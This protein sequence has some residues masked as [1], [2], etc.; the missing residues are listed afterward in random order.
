MVLYVSCD[1]K[2]MQKSKHKST[3]RIIQ[4][5]VVTF[6]ISL[7]STVFAETPPNTGVILKVNM[8]GLNAQSL[9]PSY[10]EPIGNG[11]FVIDNKFQALN[12]KNPC[13]EYISQIKSGLFDCEPNFILNTS[14]TPNDTNYNTLWGMAKI[15][16]AQAWDLSTGSQEVIVAIVDTGIDYTHPDISANMWQ[17]PNEIAGNG[18]D[19]DGNGIIDD[20]Y[21]YNAI[22]N[23]GNPMDDNGH[24]THCAGTIGGVGNNSR[25]VAGVNWNIKMIGAKF[26]SGS[27]SGSLSDAIKALD[28][29]TNLKNSGVN[30]IASNNSWGGGGFSSSLK[31][32]IT[33]AKNAG[34]IFVAAAGNSANNNDSSPSYP[35]SYDVENVISVAATDSNDNLA[36]FSNYGATSVDIAA[37]GVQINSTIP[38]NRYSYFSGTSMA[39]PHVTGAIALLKSY[40]NLSMTQLI[41]RLYSTG[42]VL[43]Q[44]NGVVRMGKRLNV[45]KMLRNSETED[46]APPTDEEETCTYTSSV[47]SSF[48]GLSE[49]QIKSLTQIAEDKDEFYETISA[50]VPFFD[51]QITSLSVS[52]NGVVYF[53]P[54]PSS[55]DYRIDTGVANQSISVF[56]TDLVSNIYA[57]L[58]SNGRQAIGFESVPF[59]NKNQAKTYLSLVFDDGDIIASVLKD[60]SSDLGNVLMGIKNTGNAIEHYKGS[61]ATLPNSYSIKY[62]RSCS[63]NGDGDNSNN[64][65]TVTKLK[66]KYNNGERAL[67]RNKIRNGNKAARLIFSH[68]PAN[69]DYENATLQIGTY[70]CQQKARFSL[71]GDKSSFFVLRFKRLP[72]RLTMDNKSIEI[73][74]INSRRSRRRLRRSNHLQKTR[75][76]VRTARNEKLCSR[77]I[78]KIK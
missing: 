43:S 27:G 32:A 20:V 8:S 21:G 35:A 77:F 17:N 29:L 37:P 13:E 61:S 22:N 34:I 39:T 30:I 15:Q 52:P 23:S 28:Y 69:S 2:H 53:G 62:T 63:S 49:S 24:G 44:M 50:D 36:S 46:P 67:K 55:M 78:N 60:N 66:V 9:L 51:E 64:D 71:D 25:G 70:T 47:L 73:K 57:G 3:S 33:R 12:G 26:L 59:T 72:S 16:A 31:S 19:D 38:G 58:D 76:I 75:G 41:N 45:N 5:F 65:V 74:A 4:F 11:L 10:A 48:Q 54:A 18:I 56:H 6:F 1:N 68:T 42:D 40:S 14:N 7:T